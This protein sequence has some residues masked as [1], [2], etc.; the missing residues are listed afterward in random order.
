LELKAQGVI[1]ELGASVYTPDEALEA[2]ADPDVRHLQIP[3][4]ILDWRWEA[5]G[6]PAAVG[7]RPDLTVYAR[8]AYL[9]GILVA[10]AETWP[11]LAGVDPARWIS[12]LDDLACRLGRESR[13]DLCLAFVLS[14]PW[15]D[16]VV[17][18]METC[19]QLHMNLKLCT[20]PLL[21]DTAVREAAACLNHAPAALLNPAGW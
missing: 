16:T 5:A 3:Y 2:V 21:L 8:G 14:Q 20:G 1:G 18:G 15:I 7:R 4:N 6:V 10:G 19:G 13:A 9:Q 12:A 11:S 17:L